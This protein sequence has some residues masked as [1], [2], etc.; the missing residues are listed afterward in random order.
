MCFVCGCLECFC[1]LVSALRVGCYCFVFCLFGG[2]CGCRG[3]HVAA[4]WVAA[5]VVDLAIGVGY[6]CGLQVV[7]V[8]LIVGFR[9]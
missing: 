9:L 6:L 4:V 5:W 1:V 8:L 3:V 7:C 2:Y